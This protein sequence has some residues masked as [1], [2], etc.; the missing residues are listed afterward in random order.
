MPSEHQI[1]FENKTAPEGSEGDPGFSHKDDLA[2]AYPAS[3]IHGSTKVSIVTTGEFGGTDD[4]VP[5]TVALSLDAES[6]RQFYVSF[7]MS[8]EKNIPG[9]S[10]GSGVHMNY[11]ENG[12]VSLAS[13]DPEGL[14]P[15]AGS[16]GSTISATGLGPNVNTMDITLTN[17]ADGLEC[18]EPSKLVGTP[19][20]PL[21]TSTNIG[22]GGLYGGPDTN[23]TS[24]GDSGKSQA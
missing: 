5:G 1:I 3:P 22:Q 14:E 20:E 8:G 9:S 19:V 2:T 10:F 4:D 12:L 6:Y 18:I 11:H 23:P 15:A 7:V 21:D 16:V 24:P 17:P 13:V